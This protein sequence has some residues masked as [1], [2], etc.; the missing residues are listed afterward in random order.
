MTTIEMRLAQRVRPEGRPA[1]YHSWRHLTFLHWAVPAEEM[2]RLLPPGLTV[3]TFEGVAY[4]GLVAFTMCDMR[5]S[6][7]PALPGL[8]AS[9]ETNVRTYVVDENGVPGVWFFSLDAANLAFVHIARAWYYLPYRKSAMRIRS[10]DEAVAYR[11]DSSLAGCAVEVETCGELS[12]AEPG[13]L[14]FFLI[15]RYVLYSSRRGRLFSGRVHHTPYPLRA[16][17]CGFVEEGLIKATQ[18][19]RPDV[20]PLVHFSPGVDV[21]VFGLERSGRR[22]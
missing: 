10:N 9:H 1:M 6:W 22:E 12:V 16:V 3:D 5:L 18:I 13:S 8:R 14:A 19:E 7:M 2:Q 20:A 4:V 15:E 21:E 11:S 17:Q